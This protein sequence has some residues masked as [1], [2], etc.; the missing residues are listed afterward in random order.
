MKIRYLIISLLAFLILALSIKQYLFSAG[1]KKD[2]I[3]NSFVISFLEMESNIVPSLASQMSAE[4]G[5]IFDNSF[6]ADKSKADKPKAGKSKSASK[7]GIY[8]KVN[9]GD[10]LIKIARKFNIKAESIT[11]HN[12]IDNA[13]IIAGQK[14]FL[15]GVEPQ[16]NIEPKKEIAAKKRKE[17]SK[18]ENIENY[19]KENNKEDIAEKR[20]EKSNNNK[21]VLSWPLRGPITSGFGTRKSPFAKGKRFHCGLDIGAEEGTSVKAAGDGR[22]IFSGWK[23]VYGNMIVIEHE[24]NYLTIYAHN[25]S[26]FVSEDETV[27]RGD[28]IAAS[29]KTGAV[30]GAHLHF[31]IRKGVVPLNPL[32]IL[33]K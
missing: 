16:K 23:D 24:N 26:N 9:S 10:T 27:K 21:L 6:I 8:Y 18:P 12:K 13:K 28:V 25:S 7:K 2:P 4:G 19:I 17:S 1:T 3:G 32:R 5:I 33:S 20:N 30:T 14:I 29:G 15:P 31:E 22:V 11:E